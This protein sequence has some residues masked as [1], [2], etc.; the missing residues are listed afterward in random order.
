[1][2]FNS[3]SFLIFYLVVLFLYWTIPQR[4][5]NLLLLVAS[6][7]FYMSSTPIYT[8]LLTLT[9]ISTWLAA[10]RI[11]T[12]KGLG[13]KVYLWVA[14]LLNI[15]ILFTFKYY[16]FTYSLFADAVSVFGLTLPHHELG[17]ILPV[18][19]SFYTFQSI[20]YIIDVYRKDFKAEKS[21]FLYALFISFF[22]QLVAG[23]IER[24]SNL[25]PQFCK[26]KKFCFEDFR[27][28][29][30][31]MLWGFF[32]KLCLADRC[33]IY[34]DTIYN[35]LEYHNGGSYLLASILFYFQIYG[36]FCGYS[37]I[38]IGCAKMLGFNMMQNFKRPFFA[39]S[40]S[41]FWRRWHISLSSWMRDY[42]YI[43]LGGSRCVKL[44]TMRNL[45][46]TM[47]VSGL[48]HG[49]SLT[50]VV[51]GV[52]HGLAICME[53]LFNVQKT[54][55]R[56]IIL[57][58]IRTAM[59]FIIVTFIWIFFRADTMQDAITVITGI[60]YNI[61]IPFRHVT[62]YVGIAAALIVVI[63]FESVQEK[64]ISFSVTT[65]ERKKTVLAGIFC[66]SIICYILL[67][68]VLNGDQFIYFQ[69]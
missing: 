27:Y 67:F 62:L 34:V 53:K 29:F 2:I 10:L 35:N 28:G 63:S 3:I 25:L 55:G 50:Y 9:T 51:W 68:G 37:L 47:F 11:E 14:L 41:E 48:W 17:W 57:R 23:P 12:S 32:L 69:F 43:P 39:T 64:G 42:I 44:K 38:A 59:T 8:G 7:C 54:A 52:L 19:I 65:S 26:K 6:Y 49:A 13:R 31:I 24:S 4:Y 61:G 20:G 36:D 56:N 46:I 45:L 58:S 30:I 33:G 18:G 22:P 66:I 40:I 21:L 5:R 60:F 15:G 1:M 16:D